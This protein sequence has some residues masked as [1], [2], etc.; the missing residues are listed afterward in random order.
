M[1]NS[2]PRSYLWKTI[3]KK[4]K[5]E[6]DENLNKNNKGGKNSFDLIKIVVFFQCF[7][8]EKSMN[9]EYFLVANQLGSWLPGWRECN[10]ASELSSP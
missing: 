3:Y 6:N 1:V 2:I 9:L 4:S 5:I 8:N 7:N 10:S